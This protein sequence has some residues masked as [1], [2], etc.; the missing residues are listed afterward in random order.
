MAIIPWTI[1]KQIS[2][3]AIIIVIVV[4]V[5]VIIVANIIAPTCSDGKQN[6]EEQG[7]DCGGPCPKQCLGE[8]KDLIVLWS[9]FFDIGQGKYDVVAMIENPNLFLALPS[10]K[11]RFKLYDKN[12]IMI[13]SIE[14]E[15][16]INP[17]ETYPIFET[18]VAVGG[19]VPQKAFI[20][21]EENPQW[22]LFKKNEQQLVVSKKQFFNTPPFP[23][24]IISVSNK[25][26]SEIK[27]IYTAAIL[28]DKDK[29]AIGASASKIESV[30]SSASQDIVFT[31]PKLLPEDPSLIEVFFKTSLPH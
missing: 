11:Y 16:F 7:I 6:Q 17:G 21:L 29:N 2:Y 18:G 10:F 1:K 13:T 24:L 3:L 20:E 25:S 19:R 4:I 23:R 26:A 15:A 27:N 22:E 31:W 12:N 5:I 28:Y 30:L 14:G 8:I 9:K